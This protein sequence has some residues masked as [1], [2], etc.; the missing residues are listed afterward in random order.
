MCIL[1]LLVISSVMIGCGPVPAT[2][3]NLNRERYVCKID[4]SK[5]SQYQGK[6]ILLSTIIDES[7]NTSNLY[8][9][10]PEQTIGYQLYYSSRSMQQPVVSYFWYALQKAFE[11]GGIRI[12]ER[13][14]IYDAELSLVF[15]SLLEM[16]KYNSL[17]TKKGSLLYSKRY[18]IRM[19]EVGTRN[20][21]ILEQRAYGML[22]SI[23]TTILSDPD[24]QNAIAK[25]VD[26]SVPGIQ[27]LDAIKG[28]VLKGGAI[29]KGRIL[30]MNVN[31]VKIQT[32]DGNI[33]SYLF[34]KEIEAFITE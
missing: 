20:V 31:M 9:Y 11:C 22:D 28:V 2:L 23:V 26:T 16:K 1:C 32:T 6:R 13:G 24:F 33:S 17:L 19:P 29:V 25:N 27:N 8:F 18:E 5:F 34:D 3:V 12:E 10:N 21:D 14:P 7:K 30:D 4:P 15:K